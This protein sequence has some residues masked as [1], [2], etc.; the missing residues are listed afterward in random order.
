[1]TKP[2]GQV[3]CRC[4]NNT[5]QLCHNARAGPRLLYEI[6]MS[7]CNRS[8]WPSV[9]YRASAAPRLPV[10]LVRS[11]R[12]LHPFPGIGRNG[13]DKGILEILERFALLQAL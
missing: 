1:V 3:G 4:A 10:V 11:S 8:A 9:L 6:C 2:F 5:L 7:G 12:L 13:M